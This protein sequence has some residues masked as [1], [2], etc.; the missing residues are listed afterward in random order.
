MA[1]ITE[2]YCFVVTKD[3]FSRETA[4]GF[5]LNLQTIFK[6]FALILFL[7]TFLD[8]GYKMLLSANITFCLSP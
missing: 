4:K 2:Y 3:I 1:F 5:S 8:S 7:I 6:Q